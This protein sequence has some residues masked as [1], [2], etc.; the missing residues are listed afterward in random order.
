MFDQ[1]GVCPAV[2]NVN[3]WPLISFIDFEFTEVS[4]NA[5]NSTDLIIY[6]SIYLFK[7]LFTVDINYGQS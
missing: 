4:K 1:V 3:K 7:S 6:L 2:L 5:L